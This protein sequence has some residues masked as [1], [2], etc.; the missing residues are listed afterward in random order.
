MFKRALATLGAILAMAAAP[1]HA[2]TWGEPQRVAPAPGTGQSFGSPQLAF[3]PDGTAIAQWGVASHFEHNGGDWPTGAAYALRAPGAAWSAPVAMSPLYGPLHVDRAGRVDMVAD[4]YGPDGWDAQEVHRIV[5]LQGRLT[6]D[7]ASPLQTQ[8]EIWPARAEALASAVNESRAAVAVWK[9]YDERRNRMRMYAALRPARGRFGKPILLSN[10]TSAEPF[11]TAAAINSRGD[12]LV[13]WQDGRTIYARRAGRTRRLGPR[14]RVGEASARGDD[15]DPMAA[16]IDPAGESLVLWGRWTRDAKGADILA[17]RSGS[18]GF[19]RPFVLDSW[20]PRNDFIVGAWPVAQS[21]APGETL[22]AWRSQSGTREGLRVATVTRTSV[23]TQ[24]VAGF[25]GYLDYSI[26]ALPDGRAA[27]AWEEIGSSNDLEVLASLRGPGA[28][29]GP[30][31][32]VSPA[33]SRAARPH[34]AI[35]PVSGQPW[36]GMAVEEKPGYVAQPA[37]SEREP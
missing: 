36:V 3:G 35:N 6:A 28:A 34:V 2:A 31:E 8:T 15:S 27:I 1:A 5:A 19:R 14:L 37:V 24:D 23:T 9:G 30:A 17:A 25:R 29:F 21:A 18:R 12:V 11:G 7:G 4:E 32:R 26:D 22:V 16:T 13:A 33:G 20:T 10:R